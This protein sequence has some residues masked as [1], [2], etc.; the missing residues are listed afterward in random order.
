MLMIAGCEL[1]LTFNEQFN[2]I[3]LTGKYNY[4]NVK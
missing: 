4:T 1:K 2:I 3:F